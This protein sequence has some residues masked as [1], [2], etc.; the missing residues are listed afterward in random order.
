M[1]SSCFSLNVFFGGVFPS[2]FL[3]IF[4]S[5]VMDFSAE[6]C[7][8]NGG[9]VGGWVVRGCKILQLSLVRLLAD[10]PG[11]NSFGTLIGDWFCGTLASSCDGCDYDNLMRTNL[12]AVRNEMKLASEH[13]LMVF[14]PPSLFLRSH[15]YGDDE[16]RDLFQSMQQVLY[17]MG[18]CWLMKIHLFLNCLRFFTDCHFT[19]RC[20]VD[21]FCVVF[22]VSTTIMMKVVKWY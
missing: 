8:L 11:K 19:P 17:V 21:R 22:V 6:L 3:L 5:I 2:F 18:L 1:P 20:C 16:T 13:D 15:H 4:M 7:G 9:W 14:P 12:E 10:G